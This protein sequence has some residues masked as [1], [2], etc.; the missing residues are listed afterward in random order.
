MYNLFLAILSKEKKIKKKGKSGGG[1]GFF[2][3]KFILKTVN[4]CG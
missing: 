2:A 4:P 1:G 3:V